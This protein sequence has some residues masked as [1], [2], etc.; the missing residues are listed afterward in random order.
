MIIL[1]VFLLFDG[2]LTLDS[3]ERARAAD[4][5]IPP[6]NNYERFLDNTFNSKYLR[7]MF[8]NNW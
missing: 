4:K 1:S 2:L 8:N 7:N 6:R 5:G 3:M